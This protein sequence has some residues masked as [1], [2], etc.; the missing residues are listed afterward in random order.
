MFNNK[1]FLRDV[2]VLLTL[3]YVVWY[4]MIDY[5]QFKGFEKREF[6]F[7]SGMN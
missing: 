2:F 1:H 5:E 6:L 4:Y 7:D 3:H